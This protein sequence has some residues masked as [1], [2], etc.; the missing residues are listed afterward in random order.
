MLILERVSYEACCSH[1]EEAHGTSVCGCLI[2][3]PDSFPPI[4][5]PHRSVRY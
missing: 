4:A 1:S 5:D 3:Q 2:L